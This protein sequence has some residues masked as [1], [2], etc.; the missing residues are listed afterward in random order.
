MNDTMITDVISISINLMSLIV[1]II[2]LYGNFFEL[3]YQDNRSNRIFSIFSVSL[4][5]GLLSDTLSYAG[6]LFY[7]ADKLQFAITAASFSL[8]G[9]IT[10][11]FIIY[12]L[13]IVNERKAVPR[14]FYILSIVLC[15]INFFIDS[16]LSISGHYFTLENGIYAEGGL[17][18][19][20][21]DMSLK[22]N[23]LILLFI[24]THVKVLGLHD[25][26]AFISYAIFPTIGAA[27]YKY[28]GISVEYAM[29]TISILLIFIMVQSDNQNK[30]SLREKDLL[31]KSLT[32]RMTGLF[33]RAAHD[34]MLAEYDSLPRNF[35]YI[36][37]DLNGLKAANDTYGHAAGDE[38]IIGAAHCIDKC[39]SDYGKAFRVG[40]D[41][42]A[43]ILEIETNELQYVIKDFDDIV[44][45]WSGKLVKNMSISYGYAT[46]QEFCH[47]KKMSID[48]LVKIADGR[49]YK[50]KIKHYSEEGR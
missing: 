18:N 10:G 37:F 27:I 11:L 21:S 7:W 48:G 38:L 41:E 24:L 40:G 22:L 30:A 3:H 5:L 43:A 39:F 31:H 26:L 15:S 49:M 14:I 13:E 50:S 6:T 46:I 44:A 28:F 45:H 2:V 32:D 12:L 33:N 1:L 19:L 47:V 29:T 20:S 42:F 17:V 36:S 8:G 9:I 4:L 16:A 34:I 35:V 23:L 25:T